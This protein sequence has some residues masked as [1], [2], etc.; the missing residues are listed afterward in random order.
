MYDGPAL[1]N[2]VKC[3]AYR[4]L[5]TDKTFRYNDAIALSF[6]KHVSHE[7]DKIAQ[8]VEEV[9]QEYFELNF[10]DVFLSSV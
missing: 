8:L 1:L 10:Q 3:Q 4:M 7:S 2:K 9:C 5:F 6:R